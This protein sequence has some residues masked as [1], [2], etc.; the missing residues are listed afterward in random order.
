MITIS[1]RP[2]A[3]WLPVALMATAAVGAD[4]PVQPASVPW[5]ERVRGDVTFERVEAAALQGD[6][7]TSGARCE[8]DGVTAPATAATARSTH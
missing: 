1:F 6:V 5:I 8:A 7:T 4:A 2:T 3:R